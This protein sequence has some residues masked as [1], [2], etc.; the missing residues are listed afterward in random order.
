MKDRVS[1]QKNM[2]KLHCSFVE[3]LMALKNSNIHGKSTTQTSS[4]YPKYVASTSS[5]DIFILK[6]IKLQNSKSTAIL[7][8]ELVILR[9]YISLSNLGVLI[10]NFLMAL[11]IK[12]PN[13]N[14]SD[15]HSGKTYLF[16]GV[17]PFPL[18]FLIKKKKKIPYAMC[19]K[20]KNI[21]VTTR[22]T[23]YLLRFR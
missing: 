7:L 6:T 15:S 9:H 12:F 13:K 23:S 5:H 8:T 22:S 14:P 21:F 10:F 17:R 3:K 18:F 19:L 1:V 2:A 4:Q 16:A 11:F 20:T